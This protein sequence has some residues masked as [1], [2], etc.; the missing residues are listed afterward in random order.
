MVETVPWEA[1]RG[2]GKGAGPSAAFG[3]RERP[4]STPNVRTVWLLWKPTL[5]TKTRTWRGWGTRICGRGRKNKGRDGV[6]IVLPT[7][8]KTGEG[9]GTRICG[10]RGEVR[11][12]RNPLRL[13]SIAVLVCVLM[14]VISPAQ[15]A[16]APGAV[17]AQKALAAEKQGDFA[18]AESAWRTVITAQ[19]ANAQAFAHLG[20]AQARQEHFEDA[21]A[22]YRKA[23][24]LNPAIPQLDMN[25]GLA[26]FKAGSFKDAIHSFEAEQKAAPS[27]PGAHRLTILLGMA[28]YGAHEYDKAIPYLK[29]AAAQDATNLSLQL[30]LA[31][32]YLWTKQFQETL[33]VYKEILLIDPDSAEA[34]M[35]A[36]EALD[37]KGDKEGAEAQFRAAEK[38]NPK[39]P[40]VHFGLAYLLWTQKRYEE[41][42]PEFYAELANDPENNM[43]MIYLGDTYVQTAQYDKGKEI[44]EKALGYQTKNP[45]IHLDLGIVYQET[46]DKESAIRELTRTVEIAPDTVNAHFRLA[47]IYQ[48]MGRKDEAKVEF[49]KASSLNKARD[50][51]LHKQIEEANA[52]PAKAASTDAQEPAPPVNR[53]K[54]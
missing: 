23:Q 4:N 35:I 48:S 51:G 31:H 28:H 39:E 50:E 44:L 17:A 3:P 15:P 13:L 29:A 26:Q 7:L 27:G 24:Q 16:A 36:G 38:V 10:W 9:W 41:A 19:P 43:A 8:P 54:P 33:G 25:L 14:E 46:G 40:N 20:L 12:G 32:C 11:C 18:G 49:A 45:L 1:S 30:S 53:E 21:I 6:A 34:D 37:E 47:K 22:S 52:R 5:A 2:C 42:I